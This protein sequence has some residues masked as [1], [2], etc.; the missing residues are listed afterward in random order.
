LL[1]PAK[2]LKQHS[3]QWPPVPADIQWQRN[4]L[5]YS[6]YSSLKGYTLCKDKIAG[7]SLQLTLHDSH[8]FF[9]DS[10]FCNASTK[11]QANYMTRVH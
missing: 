6:V 7:T 10:R 4:A 11:A 8:P 5:I 1:K 3:N 2:Q 9:F